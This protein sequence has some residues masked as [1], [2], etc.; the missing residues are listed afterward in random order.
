M[1]AID[2]TA[3]TEHW[4]TILVLL[5]TI[6]GAVWRVW[7]KQIRPY[8]DAQDAARAE[9]ASESAWVREQM[10]A[11]GIARS[12]GTDHDTV[13][14]S[15]DKNTRATLAVQ[16]SMVTL[17]NAVANHNRRLDTLERRDE[18]SPRLNREED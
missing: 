16:S 12:L 15:L 17:T 9:Q 5:G 2:F 1:F 13:R 6:G 3:S 11:N 4:L 10:Q 14:D 8:M 7:K 18:R